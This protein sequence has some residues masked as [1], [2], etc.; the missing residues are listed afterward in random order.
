MK[1]FEGF[2]NSPQFDELERFSIF[3]VLTYGA[4]A[5]CTLF[6]E[7]VEGYLPVV[8]GVVS[9]VAIFKYFLYMLW[10]YYNEERPNK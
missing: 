2:L 5:V 3:T 7:D 10:E 8:M 1:N 6:M 9:L 4:V